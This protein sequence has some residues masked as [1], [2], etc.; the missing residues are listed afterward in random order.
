MILLFGSRNPTAKAKGHACELPAATPPPRL[1]VTKTDQV[2]LLYTLAAH[3]ASFFAGFAAVA[4]LASWT[5]KKL[6]A[7]VR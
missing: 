3:K 5:R 7:T 2:N 4:F 6:N 1:L